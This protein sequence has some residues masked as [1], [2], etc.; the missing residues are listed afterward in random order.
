MVEKDTI[1]KEQFRYNGMADFK[2]TYEYAHAWLKDED[3]AINEEK[4]EEV[5]KPGDAK[6][7]RVKWVCNKKITD[8]FRIALEIKWQILNMTDVEVEIDGKKKKMNKF[9]ELKIELKGVLEKDYNSKWGAKGF[10]KFLREVYNKYIIPQ[11]TEEMEIK[12]VEIVQEFK[13]EMK[14]YL[15]LTGKR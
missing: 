4:Y 12:T 11:R 7:I 2:D 14:S 9:S 6:E 3:Y 8:Y 13:E 5:A 1:I 15:N 10:N